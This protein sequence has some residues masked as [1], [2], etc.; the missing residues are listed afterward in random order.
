VSDLT[1]DTPTSARYFEYGT[2]TLYGRP[3]QGRSAIE[4]RSM[5]ESY[6]P[7]YKYAVW[8]VPRS[9]ATTRGISFLISF[10]RLLRCFS[11]PSIPFSDKC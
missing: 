10:P 1:Q 2:V 3:F 5:L 11:S 6:N 9:L 8:A 7:A 4:D